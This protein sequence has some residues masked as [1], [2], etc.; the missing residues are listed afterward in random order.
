MKAVH[1]GAGNIGRGF[2]GL[3]LHDSGYEVVFADVDAELVGAL[4]AAQ[5][6]MVR[7][8]GERSSERPV[9]NFRAI[10]SQTDAEALV[11]EIATADILTTAVGVRILPFVAPAI[12]AGL[13]HRPAAAAPLVVMA[14]E[15]AVGATDTLAAAV[16]SAGTPDEWAAIA[17]KAVFANTAVDRIVPAQPAGTGID[18][19]VEEFFEWVVDRTPFAGQPPAIEGVRFVDDLVPYIERKLY[20]VNTGH[21]T[22]AYA[23][24]LAGAPTI[25]EAMTID[26]VRDAASRVLKETSLALVT[27]HGLDPAGMAAYRAKILTRFEN[28]HLHDAVERVGREPLRKLGRYDR[29]IGP[30]AELAEH[31]STPGALLEAIEN[32]LRFDVPD[33]PQSQELGAL[34]RTK[35]ATEVVTE[36]TTLQAEHPLFA[37]LVAVVE[38]AQAKR[39]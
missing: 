12:A 18:V 33:D 32:V 39:A 15:N 31:R 8:V 13:V 4:A 3:L 14:C 16:R 1:F 5:S 9:T 19:V 30:A 26:S 36:V 28:A 11:A 2:V 22:V 34:L 25:A 7:A 6:Y 27:K 24:F 38:S 23:G 21:A 37:P 10:N 17:P 20:T 29:F 35:P